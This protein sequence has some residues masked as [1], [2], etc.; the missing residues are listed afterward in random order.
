M[1]TAT[2]TAKLTCAECRYEN[3]AERIYCHNC[4]ERLDR[5]AVVAKKKVDNAQETHRRLRKLL[6]GP[7]RTRRNLVTAG[8]LVL[9]AAAAAGLIQMILPPEFPAA[10]KV[11][12]PVQI[13]L[14]LE[15]AI[16][17]SLPL[18][19]TENDINAYLIYRLAGK[20]KALDKPLL[21]F[22]RAAV[23]FKEGV[24]TFGWERS[25]LGY[26][27]YSRVSFRVDQ[28]AKQ[29]SLIKTGGW[30]GRLPIHPLVMRYGDII[31]KDVWTALDR[32]RKL[33]MKMNSVAFH[34]GSVAITPA[35]H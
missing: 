30:I 35:G 14:E 1:T 34:D 22:D 18:N 32:E 27:I 11:T 12:S 26:P 24:C 31:F 28:G 23:V 8:K 10:V 6:Q 33:V 4:G 5:T 16:R 25:I 7:S 3:E 9:A 13:D 2:T 29:I 19:Y 17:R 21:N 20:K 15:N